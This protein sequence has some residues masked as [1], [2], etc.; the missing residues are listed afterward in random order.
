MK[1]SAWKIALTCLSLAFVQEAYAKQLTVSASVAPLNGSVELEY[2]QP[3]AETGSLV[4]VKRADFT[5]KHLSNIDF[6]LTGTR[7]IEVG[8]GEIIIIC[9]QESRFKLG[10]YT[11]EIEP[12]TYVM[13]TNENNILVVRNLRQESERAVTLIDCE[14]RRASVDAGNEFIV[15]ASDQLL[16]DLHDKQAEGLRMEWLYGN[17]KVISRTIPFASFNSSP[18]LSTI[19]QASDRHDRLL[20]KTVTALA[21]IRKQSMSNCM[22]QTRWSQ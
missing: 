7:S 19:G 22:L 14:T 3:A 9:E 18:L 5:I 4:T 6:A 10:D 21:A 15:G 12:K 17:R 11:L 13:I 2:D 1:N 20:S 8:T 16:Q